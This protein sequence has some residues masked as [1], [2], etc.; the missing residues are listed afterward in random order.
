MASGEPGGKHLGSLPEKPEKGAWGWWAPTQISPELRPEGNEAIAL[1]ALKT[2]LTPCPW[3]WANVAF[4]VQILP[5]PTWL[6][7]YLFLSPFSRYGH[8]VVSQTLTW[9]H[10]YQPQYLGFKGLFCFLFLSY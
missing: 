6:L 9:P 7:C 10:T 4:R 1:I 3:Y 2:D 5:L 8:C